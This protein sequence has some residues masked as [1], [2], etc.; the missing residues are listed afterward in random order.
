MTNDTI[1]PAAQDFW[2][3]GP[4]PLIRVALWITIGG[5]KITLL[6]AVYAYLRS[7]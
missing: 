6:W 1:T 5:A 4:S 7:H 3:K 2:R